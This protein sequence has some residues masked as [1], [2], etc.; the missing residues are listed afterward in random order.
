[1][2]PQTSWSTCTEVIK[3]YERGR[4]VTGVHFAKQWRDMIELFSLCPYSPSGDIF[5][6]FELDNL[7]DVA[8]KHEGLSRREELIDIGWQDSVWPPRERNE[9]LLANAFERATRIAFTLRYSKTTHPGMLMLD[10]NL[11]TKASKKSFFTLSAFF[12]PNRRKLVAIRMP[13]IE[14]QGYF[15]R[16]EG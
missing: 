10:A 14:A 4:N 5:A 6:G 3:D 1:M 12:V 2:F 15:I 13:T 11:F 16:R 8:E 9:I 7:P